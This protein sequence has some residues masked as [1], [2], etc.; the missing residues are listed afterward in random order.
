MSIHTIEDLMEP[1]M[2]DVPLFISQIESC[3]KALKF[4]EW[5]NFVSKN[6]ILK[7]WQYFLT[8]DPYTR[9]GLQKPRGYAGDATLMDFAYGHSSIEIHIRDVDNTGKQLYQVTASAPQSQSARLRVH[10]IAEQIK[11]FCLENEKVSI[12]SYASGHGRE[13][14][15]LSDDTQEVIQHFFAIDSD[16][17]SIEEL[18]NVRTNY[19]I[20]GICKN[21]LRVKF[22]KSDRA[23]FVY[24]LG[25]FDYLDDRSAKK[26][27]ENMWSSVAPGGKLVVANLAHNAANIAYCEAVMDWWMITRSSSDMLE[28]AKFVTELGYVKCYNVH[29]L[30]C[31]Y[32]LEIFKD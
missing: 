26:I 15:F 4:D 31:F 18:K 12:A 1:T 16:Q 25:L 20:E 23:N 29:R 27:L 11:Q 6:Y 2:E 5:K 30:G 28:L 32:Y 17:N 24:S 22:E 7:K 3:R 19:P 9:W 14:E 21:A 10:F 8:A 13:L